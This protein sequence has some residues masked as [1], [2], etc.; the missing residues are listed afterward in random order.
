MIIDVRKKIS[1]LETA[2]METREV[3]KQFLKLGK[4]M[5]QWIDNYPGKAPYDAKKQN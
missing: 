2:K 3:Q 4:I 5:A 1:A